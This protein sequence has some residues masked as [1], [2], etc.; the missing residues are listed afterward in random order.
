MAFLCCCSVKRS[1]INQSIYNIKVIISHLIIF[2][3]FLNALFIGYSPCDRING[4]WKSQWKCEMWQQ[5]DQSVKMP[6]MDLQHSKEIPHTEV[7]FSWPLNKNIKAFQYL[8]HSL[9]IIY[10]NKHFEVRKL[11][12]LQQDLLNNHISML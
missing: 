8:K 4:K 6:P 9:I 5:P 1:Q 11:K 3:Y 10:Y 12:Y 7:D 2:L